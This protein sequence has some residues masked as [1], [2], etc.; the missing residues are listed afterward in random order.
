LPKKCKTLQ[1]S[2]PSIRRMMVMMHA[3][4]GM[5]FCL[6]FPSSLLTFALICCDS[7]SRR[8]W[9]W[10]IRSCVWA[11]HEFWWFAHNLGKSCRH[12]ASLFLFLLFVTRSSFAGDTCVVWCTSPECFFFREQE[13]CVVE[14]WERMRHRCFQSH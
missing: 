6:V 10:K 2:S 9:R 1:A 13:C 7:E 12:F 8:G 3:P 11:V 5:L 4:S 14:W